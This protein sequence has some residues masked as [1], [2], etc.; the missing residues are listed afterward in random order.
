MAIQLLRRHVDHQPSQHRTKPCRWKL[1]LAA[2]T[3]ILLLCRDQ[4]SIYQLSS[5]KT[6][7]TPTSSNDIT[8]P[9]FGKAFLRTNR[10]RNATTT[11]QWQVWNR[12]TALTQHDVT[13]EWA[14]FKPFRATTTLQTDPKICTYPRHQDRIVSASLKRKGHWGDCNVLSGLW[15]EAVARIHNRNSNNNNTSHEED[16]K[17]MIYLEAGGN[18]G[19]CVMEMLHSTDAKI[20]VAEPH[21]RNQAQMTTTLMALPEDMRN[22]VTLFPIGVGDTASTFP[23]NMASNNAGNSVINAFV[24]DAPSQQFLAPIQVSVE[25]LDSLLNSNSVTIPLF[26]MDIQGFECRALDG[27]TSLLS[28]ID[29]IRTEVAP[30]FLLE[31]GCSPEGLKSRF[32]NNGFKIVSAGADLTAIRTS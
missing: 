13:C 7:T 29:T 21:P 31:Q 4:P 8:D 12:S 25:R 26:K 20:V 23:L 17:T 1:L 9:I 11:L 14:T 15:T 18:I 5:S 19:S 24:K 27:M 3:L 2:S 28:R 10:Y 32:T 16:G 22:R 6:A 30:P